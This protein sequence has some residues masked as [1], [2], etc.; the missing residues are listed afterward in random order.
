MIATGSNR[1]HSADESFRERER[2]L[3]GTFLCLMIRFRQGM[4]SIAIDNGVNLL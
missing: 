2:L 4:L 1:N 3:R